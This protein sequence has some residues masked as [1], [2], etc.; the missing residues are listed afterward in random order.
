MNQTKFNAEP[1]P[2]VV[3]REKLKIVM[4]EKGLEQRDLARLFGS[5]PSSVSLKMSGQRDFNE[6]E[7]YILLN[8]FGNEIFLSN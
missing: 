1:V 7:I 6:Q 2:R 8:T 5:N 4:A 3:N